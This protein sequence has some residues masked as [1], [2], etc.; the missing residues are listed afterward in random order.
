MVHVLAKKIL[1]ITHEYPPIGGGGGKVIQDLCDGISSD[2]YLF[3]ILT[4]HYDDLPGI[5]KKEFL[6][7]ERLHTLRR[8][9]Y[10]ASLPAMFCF[11]WKSFWRALRLIRTWQPDLIHAHFAV[12]GGA[13]AALASILTKTQLILTIHGGDVPGGAPQKTDRWFQ[14]IKP[15]SGYIW[16]HAKKIIA[17]SEDSRQL[18]LSHYDVEIAVI[19]NGIDRKPFDQNNSNPHKPPHILFVGRFSPEKNATALPEILKDLLAYEWVCTM[20]GD[21]PQLGQLKERIQKY[22]L[23]QR[24]HLEGWLQQ[25]EVNQILCKGDIL[26][27]P[28]LRESMPM[29]GLQALAAGNALVMSNVGACPE[30]VEVEKNGYLIEPGY[31]KEFSQAVEYLLASPDKLAGFKQH[32]KTLSI[33]FDIQTVLENYRSAYQDVLKS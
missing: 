12:P 10:R 13:S 29:V 31:I 6:V 30:M 17:V 8:E 26:I 27:L 33:K 32:S 11:V 18:A 23:N 4:A 9:A 25:E 24:I 15:F 5:E 28:S 22:N 1:V 3:Y 20:I 16:K 21:G 14:F 2:N 7:I 19:P